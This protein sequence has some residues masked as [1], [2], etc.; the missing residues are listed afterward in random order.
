MG[1]A[2]KCD[3]YQLDEDGDW[4]IVDDPDDDELKIKIALLS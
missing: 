2:E 3:L 1:D 4:E